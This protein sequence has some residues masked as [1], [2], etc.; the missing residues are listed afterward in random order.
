MDARYSFVVVELMYV[1]VDA[2]T[3]IFL[4]LFLFMTTKNNETSPAIL[5]LAINCSGLN[6]P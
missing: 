4:L 6:D 1:L 3:T 5:N 2:A